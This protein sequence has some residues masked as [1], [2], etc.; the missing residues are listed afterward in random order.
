MKWYYAIILG[1]D[2]ALFRLAR[3]IKN[4]CLFPAEALLLILWLGA[5]SYATYRM[6]L[7]YARTE[8]MK[9]SSSAVIGVILLTAVAAGGIF[10]YTYLVSSG[11]LS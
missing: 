9:L 4:L 2:Y 11:A 8:K 10:L 1:K 7:T 5:V 3:V 6:K